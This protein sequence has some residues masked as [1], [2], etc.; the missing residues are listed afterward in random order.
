MI[1][2]KNKTILIEG[3]TDI[4]IEYF[5]ANIGSLEKQ[6]ILDY[7][8]YIGNIGSN[9]IIISK[10]NVGVVSATIATTIGILNFKPDIVINQGIA[11]A[12][13]RDLHVG[14]IVIGDK[15]VNIEAYKTPI[16]T[17]GEGSCF[18]SWEPNKRAKD[19]KYSDQKSVDY[20]KTYIEKSNNIVLVGTLGSADMFNR[21]ADR[22][23]W[24]NSKFGNLTEDME[25]IGT[26]SVCNLYKI[27]C[28]GI[29][30]IS[31]NELTGEELDKSQAIKLQKVLYDVLNNK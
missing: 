24:I 4:E 14:D 22:I 29:R 21:E 10:T 8:Y 31:N 26:Y 13:T 16:K 6:I 18:S 9:K 5:L 25:S 1:K 3:A 17:K 19:I 11:G 15:C 23:D 27:P 7:D 30:I 2:L 28:I 20:F 12:H